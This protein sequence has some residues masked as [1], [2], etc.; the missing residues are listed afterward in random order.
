M[1]EQHQVA[2]VQPMTF[3]DRIVNIFASP[4]ELY[5]NVRDTG[6]TTSNWLVPSMIFIIISIALSQL[7]LTNPD[8][9][10]QL[11]DLTR[12]AFDTAIQQGTITQEQADQQM[13]RMGPGSVFFMISAFVGPILYTFARLFFLG[14]VY[15]LLGKSAMR[16]ASPFMKV[17]EVIGLTL[18]I[19]SL[20]VLVTNI[21]IFA[22]GSLTASPSLAMVVTDFDFQNKGHAALAKVNIFTFWI[23][24]VTSIG[25]SR[26]FR[27]DLPKVLVLVV[28]L[29][30]LFSVVTVLAGLRLG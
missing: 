11:T 28:V 12:K 16:S 4:G 8:L 25:L 9:R 15:W 19:S 7:L 13:E 18:L 24:A 27:R 23:L 30:L 5:E 26:L 20:E 17:V 22:T 29:W 14:L 21:M 3:T 10:H 1:E 2:A 6:P